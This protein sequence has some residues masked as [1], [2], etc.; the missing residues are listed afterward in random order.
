LF[1]DFNEHTFNLQRVIISDLQ[2]LFDPILLY[3]TIQLRLLNIAIVNHQITF[4]AD[5]NYR[6]LMIQTL[7]HFGEPFGIQ[8]LK[9]IDIG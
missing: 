1:N 8:V 7:Q 5:Q 9:W 4:I 3:K 2:I 6:H